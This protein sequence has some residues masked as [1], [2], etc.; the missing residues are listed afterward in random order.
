M[1]NY[2]IYQLQ[3]PCVYT[4]IMIWYIIYVKRNSNYLNILSQSFYHTMKWYVSFIFVQNDKNQENSLKN[5]DQSKIESQ[6]LS[7]KDRM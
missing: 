5:R 6:N 3:K 4:L 2:R 7:L 1:S